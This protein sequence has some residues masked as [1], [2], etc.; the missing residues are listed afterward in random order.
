MPNP[1]V[2]LIICMSLAML[3]GPCLA[4]PDMQPGRWE[5]T[6]TLEMPGMAFSMPASKHIQCITAEEMVPQVQQ[7]KNS[8]CRVVDQST[9]GNVVTWQVKCESDGGSMNSHGEI[10]YHGDSFEGTVVTN[11]SQMPSEMTQEMT[12]KRLGQCN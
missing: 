9:H 8:K 12:G 4:A 10:T 5:I 3:P 1:V 2:Y 6:S 11:G 7:A